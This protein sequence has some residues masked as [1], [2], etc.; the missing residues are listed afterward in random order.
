MARLEVRALSRSYPDEVVALEDASFV[1]EDGRVAAVL[2]PSG[3]G[4]TTMLRL[5]AGLDRADAGDVLLNGRSIADQPPDQR[6]IGLM[7]QELALF[8]HLD[9]RGNVAFGLRMRHWPRDERDAR[10]AELLD[11]VGLVDKGR[12]RMHE[13]S[14]G[15]RQRVAMARALAPR[16]AVLLL[17]EPLGSLDEARKQSLRDELRDVLRR[18]ETT[19]LVV[20][21][22]LRDAIAIADDLVVMDRGRVL[23]SGPL[24]W[25]L[26]E[27]D[28]TRVARLVGYVMIAAGSVRDRVL[29][30]VGV[31]GVTLPPGSRIRGDAAV[32]G[33]PSSLL[34]VPAGRGFG[35]GVSGVV[36]RARPDGPMFVL[37]VVA[38]GREVPV[39]WE[40]DLTPP[41]EGTR[42]DI[43]ARPGTLRFFET[44]DELDPPPDT[45]GYPVHE[46]ST[47]PE[48]PINSPTTPV[49]SP[50]A[51]PPAPR[52]AGMP[53]I[54]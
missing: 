52:H 46:E 54:D 10:V 17:D 28:S 23:Q 34:G 48:Q 15:E 2:G 9:V 30:E 13:L 6:G 16:P 45:A 39:R 40:W 20:S 49:P 27:P 42:V 50:A 25:V 36:R 22:D 53:A 19:A 33:H 37:D 4:K 18:L 8:P 47:A 1:V 38:G 41:R 14:G 11:A 44:V 26:A 7:F 3:C 29:T 12:R 35:I 21:H 43:A 31:G 24:P 32:L 5:I 51:Q